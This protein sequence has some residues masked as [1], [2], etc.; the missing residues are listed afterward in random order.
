MAVIEIG[1]LISNGVSHDE[2]YSWP[3]LRQK[4]ERILTILADKT[5]P[6]LR[7]VN[8]FEVS[9]MTVPQTSVF[10]A[11][12]SYS[13]RAASINERES[14]SRWVIASRSFSKRLNQ[15]PER[16]IEFSVVLE[17]AYRK[18]YYVD[19]EWVIENMT[20]YSHRTTETTGDLHLRDL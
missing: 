12:I 20:K 7:V 18:V 16:T 3:E 6:Q 14:G 13:V 15:H 9:W 2:Y 4:T 10:H 17:D 19:K 5:K 1:T 11:M 8:A